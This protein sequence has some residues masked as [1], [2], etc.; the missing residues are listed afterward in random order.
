MQ[1]KLKILFVASEVD[2][3]IKTGGLADVSSSLPQAIEELGHDIRV[4]MPEYK[5]IS[6]RYINK[7]EHVLHYKTR[8]AWRNNYVGINRLDNNGIP[9]YFVDNKNYFNRDTIYEEEDR[10]IQFAYFCRAVLEM[11]PKIDFK[12]DIIHCND[13]QTGPL[14]MILKDNYKMYDFYEDIKTVYTIHNLKYQGEF[15]KKIL[16][17]VLCLDSAHWKSGVL[18]HNN[19]VNYMKMGINMSDTVTTVSKTYAKEITTPYFGEG[20]DYVIR[21]NEN[22][23]YGI[24]NGIDYQKNNP[25]ND[26]NIYANYDLNNLEGKLKNKRQLQKDMGLSIR[27]EVPVISIVSRLV[28]QKGLDLVK[29]IIDDLMQEDIQLII[30]GTGEEKYEHFFQQIAK[31]YPDKI[32]T[33][34]KYDVILAQKIYAGS[35]IFLMPSKYEPCGLSQLISLRYGTIPIVRETGGLKDTISA[36]DEI[37]N[38]GN[39]FSFKD[40][41]TQDMLD[42]ILRA[43]NFYHQPN[44]WKQIVKNAMNSDFSWKNSAQEYINLYYKT[45]D[46]G[47]EKMNDNINI[48]DNSKININLASIDELKD[49]KG[50]GAVLAKNI[51]DYRKEKGQFKDPE[52]LMKIVGIGKTKYNLFKDRVIV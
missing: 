19:F 41:D 7:L 50:V 51:L 1:D 44:I 39:G 22:D 9:T 21:M 49:L 10:H 43:I 32:A 45:L 46:I 14:S 28:E 47:S 33:N 11:L 31:Y 23:V 40:Y 17:D 24:V 6:D 15:G 13:W 25:A 27:D 35:D 12:P 34:I 42:T 2:P 4:V 5:Q 38:Q 52:D 36:Y 18:K 8:V 29:S 37:T 26:Q 48:K 16:S 20:L 30:L 3:F